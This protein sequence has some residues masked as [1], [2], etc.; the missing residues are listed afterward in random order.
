MKRQR[1]RPAWPTERVPR[2][3]YTEKPCLEKLKRKDEPWSASRAEVS[4][5]RPQDRATCVQGGKHPA[6]DLE[7]HRVLAEFP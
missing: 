5:H 4:V 6:G 1:V 7:T 3:G 2:Q